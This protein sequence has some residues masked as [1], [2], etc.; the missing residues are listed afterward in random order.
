[1]TTSACRPVDLS[2]AYA[3]AMSGRVQRRRLTGRLRA[4]SAQC[5][6]NLTCYT[7]NLY[8][9]QAGIDRQNSLIPLGLGHGYCACAKGWWFSI[10]REG[11]HHG[12]EL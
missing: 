1:M 6:E 7:V 5:S 2:A 12:R 9:L 10:S 3:A 11:A 4:K 8:L